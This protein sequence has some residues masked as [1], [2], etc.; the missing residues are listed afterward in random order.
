MEFIVSN[1]SC[2]NSHAED[3]NLQNTVIEQYLSENLDALSTAGFDEGGQTRGSIEFLRTRFA[4]IRE[5]FI[6]FCR[7]NASKF[8]AEIER[9]L[10]EYRSIIEELTMKENELRA[11]IDTLEEEL[12]LNKHNLSL[13]RSRNFFIQ[14]LVVLLFNIIS[15]AALGFWCAFFYSNAFSLWQATPESLVGTDGSLVLF[16]IANMD[17]EHG[18]LFFA[19]PLAVAVMV[20]IIH[21]STSKWLKFGIP[22]SFVV[23]DLLFSITIEDHLVEAYNTIG[24]SYDFSWMNVTL[25]TF[26]GM[27]PS[28]ILGLLLLNLKKNLIF[29]KTNSNRAECLVLEERCDKLKNEISELYKH[30]SLVTGEKRKLEEKTNSLQQSNVNTL[31]YYSQPLKCLYNSY[32]K[33]WLQYLSARPN[34]EAAEAGGPNYEEQSRQVLK[35]FLEKAVA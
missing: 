22:L 24:V 20:G 31:W 17:T 7:E 33:G 34:N 29:D 19:V 13:S 6:A 28:L 18:L 9:R 2:V 32:F 3:E 23:M 30:L 12:N 26:F 27:I 15:V 16:Q 11:N 1:Q 25:I 35:D 8:R 4:D 5:K 21:Q 14:D 10:A